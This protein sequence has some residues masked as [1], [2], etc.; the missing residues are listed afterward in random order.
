MLKWLAAFCALNSVAAV[1]CPSPCCQGAC[2]PVCTPEVCESPSPPPP[3][4]APPCTVEMLKQR[5]AGDKSWP[6]AC[7]QTTLG[8]DGEELD[9]SEA[10]LR[11]KHHGQSTSTRADKHSTVL[12]KCRLVLELEP[13]DLLHVYTGMHMHIGV[14]SLHVVIHVVIPVQAPGPAPRAPAAPVLAAAAAA[15]AA[16][17]RS[18]CGSR[19]GCV[20]RAPARSK[21]GNK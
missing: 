21:E 18:G 15:A 17:G 19:G 13:C 4:P 11:R 5:P 12:S 1:P 16:V 10:H 9:L 14:E 7:S 8:E 20:P 6:V 2:P 3:P